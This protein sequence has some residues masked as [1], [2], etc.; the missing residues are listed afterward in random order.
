MDGIVLLAGKGTRVKSITPMGESKHSI[1]IDKKP[2]GWY[3]TNILVQLGAKHI[4]FVI[5]EEQESLAIQLGEMLNI[6]YSITVQKK[7][8]GT[9]MGILSGLNKRK[10]L[11]EKYFVIFGDSYFNLTKEF[12]SNMKQIEK[13]CIIV[14]KKNRNDLKKSGV[15]EF[16]T[17]GEIISIEEKPDKPKGEYALRGL[18]IFDNSAKEKI[19]SLKK[20][21]RNEY[22]II[23]LV[24]LYLKENNLTYLKFN[25]FGVD[26]GT[27][28]GILKLLSFLK[29]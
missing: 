20:S 8:N 15:I 18:F 21:K 19:N 9:P 7:S 29:N 4:I 6:K 1:L 24:S 2:M 10:Y 28:S 26:M 3:S 23:D 12:I 16:N 17:E 27:P 25:N 5:N 13:P 22:E 14:Q 11:E